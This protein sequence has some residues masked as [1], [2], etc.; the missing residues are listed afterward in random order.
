[1]TPDAGYQVV[2]EPDGTCSVCIWQAG[3][4][5]RRVPGFPTESAAR[6]WI[7]DQLKEGGS[8]KPPDDKS[9]PVR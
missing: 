1:M 6:D 2:I 5:P 4:M 7:R 8:Q 3:A 9:Y